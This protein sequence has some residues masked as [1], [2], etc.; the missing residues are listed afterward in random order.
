MVGPKVKSYN[1]LGKGNIN[2]CSEEASD[3]QESV[4][5][6]TICKIIVTSIDYNN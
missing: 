5:T 2:K 6:G 1:I 4:C 3:T